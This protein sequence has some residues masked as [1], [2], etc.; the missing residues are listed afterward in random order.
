ML[1]LAY[2]TEH[3]NKI[4]IPQKWHD[5]QLAGVDWLYHFRKRRPVLSLRTPESC[6]L[7]RAMAFNRHN[8]IHFFD[9]LECTRVSNLDKTNTMTV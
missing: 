5:T 3:K 8:V 4:T 9:N 6:S 2:G 7:G 1:Q